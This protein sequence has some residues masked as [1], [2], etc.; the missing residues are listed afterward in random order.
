MISSIQIAN[1]A[2]YGTEPQVLDKLAQFNFLY[3]ANGTGKTTISRIVADRTK[4]PTCNLVWE[5]GTE[6]QTL[7]YNREFVE[8]NFSQSKELK[9]IFTL[10][11]K[12]IETQSKIALAK[13]KVDELT[14]K[15]E[16]L[17]GT[18]EGQDGKGG[19]RGELAAVMEDLKNKCWKEKQNHDA[20]LSRAFEGFRNSE[21]RFRDK[22]LAEKVKNSADLRQLSDLEKKAETIFGS[23]PAEET[24]IR[25]LAADILNLE[26]HPILNKPVVGKADVDIAAMIQ[27]LGNSDWVKQG[28]A[29]YAANDKKCPFCQQITPDSLGKSLNEYFDETFEKDSKSIESLETNYTKYAE[30]I[31]DLLGSILS[32]PPKFLEVDKL[33]AQTKLLKSKIALNLQRIAGKRK[34]PSQKTQLEPIGEVIASLNALIE[35]ANSRI[36][37][38]NK[39]VSNLSKEQLTLT[40]EVWKYLV[41]DKLKGGLAEFEKQQAALNKAIESLSV[42][43]KSAQGERATKEVEIRELEKTTTSIEPTINEINA[44]LA[45]FGFV[46]FSLEKTKDGKSYRLVRPDGSDAKDTLSEGEQSFITF[47]YFYNLLRGSN[48]ESGIMTNR[49]VVFDD[50]VSSLDSAILFVVSGLIRG[51]CDDVRIGKGNIKQ[52]IVLTHNV[53]FHKQVTFNPKRGDVALNEETFWI[54]RKQGLISKVE[55]HSTNPV[56]TNYEMLWAEVRSPN[57]SKYTIQNIMRRILEHYF[58]ILGKTKTDDIYSHFTGNEYHMCRSLFSWVNAGSHSVQEDAEISIDES[59]VQGYL[60]VFRGIFDKSGHLAHYE[61]MMRGAG[62]G[63]PT[64]GLAA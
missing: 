43:I 41:G 12:S 33:E 54:V 27:K 2:S 24:A 6:L 50:P 8:R 39:M 61:M 20:K 26:S 32:A 45:S 48:S 15:I 35:N 38:H 37:E 5:G 7:V 60:K 44:V 56:K 25:L 21:E 47:L 18:L 4:F 9:G 36:S 51:V 14:A 23:A 3:G 17:T 59:A 19:K 16:Q 22:I 29:Y 42:Q 28:R 55:K 30:A 11:E 63:S 40:A 57:P 62:V 1:V 10:G 53:Y 31:Q 49:V 13:D 34:E 64:D 46:G 52:I 58:T